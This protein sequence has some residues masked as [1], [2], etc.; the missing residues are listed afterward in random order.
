[1]D[2]FLHCENINKGEDRPCY[3]LQTIKHKM[4]IEIIP[5]EYH[6]DLNYKLDDIFDL[7][8]YINPDR[9]KENFML[10]VREFYDLSESQV[11]DNIEK[12]RKDLMKAWKWYR[13]YLEKEDGVIDR[14]HGTNNPNLN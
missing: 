10:I 14:K 4:L 6:E 12:I 7:Y 8:Q 2:R 13:S 9:V 3:I 11:D 1:M 5:F